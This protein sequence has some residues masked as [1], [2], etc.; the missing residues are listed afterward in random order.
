MVSSLGWVT[1]AKVTR[2]HGLCGEVKVLPLTDFPERFARL[3]TAHLEYGDGTRRTFQVTQ[4]RQGDPFMI[5]KLAGVDTVAAAEALRGSFLVVERDQAVS[6]SEGA[7]YDCDL[8]GLE[9][10]E[11]SG[12]RLGAL[13]QVLHFPANDVYVVDA[14]GGEL[15]LPATHE[16]V[17]HID[18]ANGRMKVR[19]LDGLLD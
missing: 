3:G 18:T 1:I 17:L 13:T 16:V 19:L 7:Y 2:P 9:V 10:T 11:E 8:I 5:L 12:R 15:L 14:P 4:V 6:L